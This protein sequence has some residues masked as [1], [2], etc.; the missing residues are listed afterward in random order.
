LKVKIVGLQHR[1]T[2]KDFISKLSA[3]SI[4]FEREPK[5]PHDKFAVK[6]ISNGIHFGYVEKKY[7]KLISTLIVNGG[8]LEKK[9]DRK[10]ESFIDLYL[11]SPTSVD[12]TGFDS[13]VNGNNAGIYQIEFKVDGF[14]RK[15]IGQSSNI[16]KRLKT[17]CRELRECTH[18][19]ILM[20]LGWIENPKYFVAKV[21]Y[22]VDDK[23]SPLERQFK[24]FEK[25]VTFISATESA[26]NAIDGDLVLNDESILELKSIIS[27][28]K[29]RI[30]NIRSIENHKK[31]SLGKLILDVGIMD[32]VRMPYS[33][34]DIKNSNVLTWWNK[35]RRGNLDY[36]PEKRMNIYGCDELIEN[37][38]KI[39]KKLN[40]ITTEKNFIEQFENDLLNNKKIYETCKLSDL[41]YF[42]KIIG[43]YPDLQ[44]TK[45]I[46]QDYTEKSNGKIKYDS[47]LEG[48]LD[49]KLLSNLKPYAP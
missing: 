46:N 4:E 21:L 3:S 11:S 22:V 1:N 16:N 47:S 37:L 20:Q 8:Q 33:G 27:I 32:R 25:E 18:H 26:V 38:I 48:V 29:K 35:T 34:V 6:C 7:S 5:N 43:K 41:Q 10:E 23:L 24:L 13:L 30:K 2:T 19:N 14:H 12:A 39:N 44:N 9:I 17:H 40:E 49:Q 45:S 28:F 15:Y 42:L 31:E 36:I